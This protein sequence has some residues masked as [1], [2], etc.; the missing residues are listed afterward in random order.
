MSKKNLDSVDFDNFSWMSA[1]NLVN[2][3]RVAWKPLMELTSCPNEL[4][5]DTRMFGFHSNFLRRITGSYKMFTELKFYSHNVL[6]E[7][8]DCFILSD[9]VWLCL[10]LQEW[11]CS[12]SNIVLQLAVN[13]Q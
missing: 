5:D 7:N 13:I 3:R 11:S 12:I 9:A 1:V 2:I 8:V 6:V 10:Q 4:S